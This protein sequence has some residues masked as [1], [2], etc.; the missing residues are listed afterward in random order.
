MQSDKHTA[1]RLSLLS[2]YQKNARVLPWRNTHDPY[3][4]W[5]SEVMLQQTQVDTAIPY[6]NNWMRVFPDVFAVSTATEE[7][8]LKQWEGLGYYSRARNI[9]K[10]ADIIANEFGGGLPEEVH[11]LRKLPGVGDYIAAAIAS[12]AFGQNVPALEAN[13]IRVIA[14]LTNFQGDTASTQAKRTLGGDQN[15][16]VKSGD[17]GAANQA[18][19]DIGATICLPKN[20]KCRICPLNAHCIAFKNDTQDLVPMRKKK[21]AIP[22][23]VVVAGVI[24]ND[25]KV[26]ITKRLPNKLLGG[27][28]EFPGG[29]VEN[30][31]THQMALMRELREELGIETSIDDEIGIYDHVYTHFSVTVHAYQTQIDSGELRKIEVADFQWVE[32]DALNDFPM[33]KVDR[34]ISR[35]V[36]SQALKSK[37]L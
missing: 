7:D 21:K 24:I 28:W 10:A 6:F 15:E 12:I 35:D 27:M 19:M 31:E 1:I 26:L 36:Q 25:G 9:K 17:A 11:A 3:L 23:L 16:I 4:I 32:A 18:I 34:S 33:G 2:W 8:V 13:G 20:P 37:Q 30:G 29:K 22:H 14:R 5:I